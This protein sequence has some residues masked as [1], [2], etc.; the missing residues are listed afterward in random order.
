MSDERVHTS[1]QTGPKGPDTFD[2]YPLRPWD[3]SKDPKRFG[4]VRHDSE[5]VTTEEGTR[6]VCK[7]CGHKFK[8]WRH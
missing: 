6:L 3:A 1:H 4:V 7:N 5:P 2:C 8:L